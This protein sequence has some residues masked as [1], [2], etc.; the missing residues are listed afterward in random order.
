[1]G[2][3]GTQKPMCYG[4]VWVG[5]LVFLRLLLRVDEPEVREAEIGK[6]RLERLDLSPMISMEQFDAGHGSPELR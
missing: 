1:M 2:L 4:R 6:V 5:R 3:G